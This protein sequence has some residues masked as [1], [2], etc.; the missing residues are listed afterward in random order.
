MDELYFVETQF[1]HNK[2]VLDLVKTLVL[3]IGNHEKIADASGMD[4][5]SG[6]KQV[7]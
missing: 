6:E 2:I 4:H 7:G 3:D 1:N 5:C